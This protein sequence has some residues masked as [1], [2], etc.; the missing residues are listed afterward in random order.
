MPET[1]AY[2]P[3]CKR[4]W[5]QLFEGARVFICVHPGGLPT[6]RRVRGRLVTTNPKPTKRRC[7]TFVVEREVMPV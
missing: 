2:C 3:T 7:P 5:R 1:C 6:V 4:L